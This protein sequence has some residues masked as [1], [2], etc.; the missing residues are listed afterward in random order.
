METK[1]N[2]V[3]CYRLESDIKAKLIEFLAVHNISISNFHRVFV[4]SFLD[5]TDDRKNKT[6]Y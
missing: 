1:L 6:T 3:I 5:V 2:N 4:E